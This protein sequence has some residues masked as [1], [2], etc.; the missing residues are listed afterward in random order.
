MLHQYLPST[1]F[2]SMLPYIL[3]CNINILL[4][5]YCLLFC[6]SQYCPHYPSYTVSIF[7]LPILPLDF[8]FLYWPPPVFLSSHCPLFGPPITDLSTLPPVLPSLQWPLCTVPY[9]SL[10]SYL[11]ILPFLISFLSV[12]WIHYNT[13]PSRVIQTSVISS[14]FTILTQH[15]ILQREKKPSD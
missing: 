8:T 11:S 1:F 4:S 7:A 12:T 13:L 10:P 5:L 14:D 3:P 9:F 6:P 15:P 2:Y